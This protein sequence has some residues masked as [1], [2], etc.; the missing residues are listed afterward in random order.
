[1]A[2]K[3][4][5]TENDI[6]SAYM[7]HV[8]EHNENP[9]SVYL[10]AKANNFEESKFYAFFGSFEAIEKHIFKTF[11]DNTVLI[12]D[13]SEEYKSYDARNRLL[14]FYFTFFEILTANRSYVTH[15]LQRHK[16]SLKGLSMLSGLKRHFRSYIN[17]LDIGTI[18]VEQEK[19]GQ[20]QRRALEESAWLQLLMTLKFWMEDNSVA[21]EKTDIFIEKSVNTS[22]DVLNIVP[23][24]SVLDF[25][26]FIFKEKMNMN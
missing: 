25:G 20:F 11:F 19:I 1:M 26:K 23:L 6:V 4:T 7:D 12:L 9:K 8:L 3:K 18:D 15:S 24:K 17:D 2:K 21:F 22:F 16:N 14:S 10:F 5:I 13:K